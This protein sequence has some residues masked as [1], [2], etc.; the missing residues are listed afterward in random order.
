MRDEKQIRRRKLSA[1][2]RAKTAFFMRYYV[3]DMKLHACFLLL[4]IY[5]LM[6]GLNG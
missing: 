1:M 3:T 2:E 5:K 6:S 4:S